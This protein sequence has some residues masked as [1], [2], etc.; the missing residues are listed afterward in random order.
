MFINVT[1]CLPT[2]KYVQIFACCRGFCVCCRQIQRA[3]KQEKRSRLIN[4][5]I[6]LKAKRILNFMVLY[7][8]AI[9][10]LAEKKI[11]SKEQ[12]KMLKVK[13]KLLI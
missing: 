12:A 9:E 13:K 5:N 1:K 10:R 7:Y 8:Y 6:D 3:V 11:K 2:C 4:N